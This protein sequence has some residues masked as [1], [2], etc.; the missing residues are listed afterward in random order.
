MMDGFDHEKFLDALECILE[1][2]GRCDLEERLDHFR[3]EAEDEYW[4]EE[5]RNDYREMADHLEQSFALV[6][7]WYTAERPAR[8]AKLSAWVRGT[9]EMSEQEETP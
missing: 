5:E 9:E 7:E 8:G 6:E 2:F 1:E 3:M 4:T